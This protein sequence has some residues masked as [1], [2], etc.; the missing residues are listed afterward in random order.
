MPQLT[1]L[2]RFSE[3]CPMSARSWFVASNPKKSLKMKPVST[4]T[5]ADEESP[6]PFGMLPKSTMSIPRPGS[7]P[8]SPNAQITPLG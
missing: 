6:D 1:P 5:D 7:I 8:F 4:S 3:N 2:N